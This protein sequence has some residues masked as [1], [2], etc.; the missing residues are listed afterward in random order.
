MRRWS[1]NDARLRCA[2]SDLCDAATG[3]L[4]DDNVLASEVSVG[5]CLPP[6]LFAGIDIGPVSHVLIH[7]PGSAERRFDQNHAQR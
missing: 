2:D 4:L 1:R 3:S 5:L 7:H 6:A